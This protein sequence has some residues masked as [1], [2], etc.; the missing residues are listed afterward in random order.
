LNTLHNRKFWILCH[1]K[2]ISGDIWPI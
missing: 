1:W 2:A